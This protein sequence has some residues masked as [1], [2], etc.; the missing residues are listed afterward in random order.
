VKPDLATAGGTDTG[1]TLELDEHTRIQLVT[2]GDRLIGLGE[3]TVDGVP[4]RSNAVT[5]RPDFS[6]TDAV[7]YQDF[8]LEDTFEAEGGVVL[9]TTAIGR[10]EVFSNELIDQHDFPIA[11]PRV[12]GDQ[13]DQ[14]DWILTPESLELD[15]TVF[16]GF[17]LSF[18]FSSDHNQLHRLVTVATWEPGG[19]IVGDT[20]YTQAQCTD[21]V[22]TFDRDTH[23]TTACLKR[24]DQWQTPLGLSYQFVPRWA[25]T[26]P[27]DF[28]NCDAG[29]LLG[30]WPEHHAVKSLVQK[31]PGEDVL[32][33]LDEHGFKLSNTVQTPAKHVLFAPCDEPRPKHEVVNLWTRA[34]EYTGERIRSRYGMELEPP[35]PNAT[36]TFNGTWG[37]HYAQTADG[38]KDDWQ[39]RVEDETFY[40][41]LDGDK[42]ESHDLLYWVA[43]TLLPR[44][45][46]TGRHHFSLTQVPTHQSD[47]TEL[48]FARKAEAG[49]H[50]D[51]HVS[52]VCGSQRYAPAAMYD[53]WRGWRYLAKK[54]N[55]LGIQLGH[56]FGMN[57]TLN[58]P[59]LREHPEY[60]LTHANTKPY[61][62]GYGHNCLAGINWNSG[63][64]QWVLDDLQRWHEEGLRWLWLDSWS[65]I[66]C[67]SHDFAGD[68]S[69]MQEKAAE[70][71]G[72]LYRIGYRD[73]RFEGVS[74]FGTTGYGI[75]DPMSDYQGHVV[76]GVVGQN[77]F[78][79]RIGHE[80]MAWNEGLDVHAH[81]SRPAEELRAY[82][83]R[84]M[85]N[86]SL[87]LI[88][89][90][91]IPTYNAL[92]DRLDKR[93]LLP[94]DRGVQW[95]SPNGDAL[96]AYQAFDHPLPRGATVMRLCAG[97]PE[98]I[99]CADDT[100]RTEPW[101]AYRI[102]H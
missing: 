92:R 97:K 74:P 62:G 3:I 94:D 36:A 66:A 69:P 49:W 41:L 15:G 22:V 64:R 45:A 78:G 60:A 1:T 13:R 38:P 51:L 4:L 6:T 12:R 83:F 42:I 59:I 32:F 76:E 96:F 19:S 10:P 73:F 34:M 99:D 68:F 70:V 50:S 56:W 9:R 47:F 81:P 40:F 63:A 58:A 90:I 14:L 16:H 95:T 35:K 86:R 98:R 31:N 18:R 87:N 61:S 39:W 37:V 102:D 46:T 2:E 77:D 48:G 26:Q 54:A 21:P 89:Y 33:V 67:L 29:A 17:G 30:Y 88:D 84:Y 57:L 44:V 7:H 91:D 75:V 53:G 28:L 43:D 100:P 65:N 23:Y 79:K 5:L 71:I 20:A 101:T 8:I 11:A 82:A 52:S 55:E 85:A 93:H 25:L 27:F 24:L 80:Y 72:D